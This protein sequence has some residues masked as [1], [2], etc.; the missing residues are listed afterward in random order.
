VLIKPVAPETVLARIQEGVQLDIASRQKRMAISEVHDR[1]ARLTRR[2]R[3]IAEL[4]AIGES[5]K[6]IARRLE[7]C[8]KTVDNHQTMILE[9]LNVDNPTQLARIFSQLQPQ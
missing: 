2:E 4:L 5:C 9:K 8:H 7:I 1:L 3:E 6:Q